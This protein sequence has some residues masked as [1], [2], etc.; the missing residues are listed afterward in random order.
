MSMSFSPFPSDRAPSLCIAA[1]GATGEQARR[2]ILPALFALYY[3]GFLPEA[4]VGI[5]GYSRK[6]LTDEDL[7]SMIASTLS[8]RID[9]WE[10]LEQKGHFTYLC[11]EKHFWM[12]RDRC[13]VW[14]DR[15]RHSAQSYTPNHSIACNG[16]PINLNGEDIRNKKVK[17]FRSICRLEPCNVILGHYKDTSG[18]KVDVKLNSLTPTYF[19]AACIIHWQC[20]LG[21]RAFYIFVVCTLPD[22]DRNLEHTLKKMACEFRH[23]PGNIYHESFG[24][25][26]DLATNELILRDV[27]DEAIPVRVNNKVPGLSLQ[28]D[29]SELNLL[30]KAKYNVEVPDSY[31]HLLLDVVNGDNHLFMKSDELTAAWNILNPVLQE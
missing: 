31:E 18:D 19:A 26:I 8:C 11:H 9:H 13:A 24:H 4:N 27:L 30:Y 22:Y 16:T 29:A 17:V 6:N 21:W 3:S 25:N 15:P 23:V 1:R 10:D 28:L 2:K 14:K 7:R 5:V 20:T 12:L